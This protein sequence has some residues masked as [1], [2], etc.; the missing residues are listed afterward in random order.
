MHLLLLSFVSVPQVIT[1]Q[2]GYAVAVLAAIRNCETHNCD[3]F[4]HFF[5]L[6]ARKTIGRHFAAKFRDRNPITHLPGATSRGD[7]PDDGSSRLSETLQSLSEEV[8]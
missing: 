4:Q 1:H 8:R 6:D 7:L 2:R 5:G 3:L